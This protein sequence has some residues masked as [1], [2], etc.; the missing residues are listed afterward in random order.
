MLQTLFL[1]PHE[2]GGLP[3]FGFGWALIVWGIACVV[4]IVYLARTQGFGRDTLSYIPVLLVV[5]AAI[6][7]VAP[8]MEIKGESPGVGQF[9]GLPIRGYGVMM[10]VGVIASVGITVYRTRRM[11][12]DPEIIFSLAFYMFLA[13]I[14]GARLF[15]VI[16]YWREYAANPLAVFNVTQG[17]LVVYGSVLGGVPAGIY[18]LWRRKLPILAIGDLIAPGMLIGLAFGRVGCLMNG[19]CFGG[20]CETPWPPS[21]S[22]PKETA[23]ALQDSPPYAHQR[24][25]GQLHGVR[26]DAD[27]EGRPVVQTI[28]DDAGESVRITLTPGDRLRDVRLETADVLRAANLLPQLV[29]A[30]VRVTTGDERTVEL[31]I[32]ESRDPAEVNQ[33]GMR[34][35]YDDNDVLRITK[36]I[37]GGSAD[38]ARLRERE[39]IVSASLPP[40]ADIAKATELPEDTPGDVAQLLMLFAGP[41]VELETEDGRIAELRL[42][43]LPAQTRPVHP[44]QIYSAINA[45]LLCGFLWVLYPFR[46][47]DGEV[48]A[49]MLL[50]YPVARFLLESIRNDEPAQFGTGLTIAQLVSIGIFVCGAALMIY[51]QRRPLCSAL[52]PKTAPAV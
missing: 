42:L 46:R 24:A 28:Y 19:C 16:E 21:I 15:F 32:R 26:L 43:E 40:L 29:G 3:V 47:R 8:M 25:H 51:L 30:K 33:I 12:L 11:G 49:A 34:A 52:P 48:F 50:L 2:I 37:V 20:V 4:G 5:A 23:Y 9:E 13:G 35:R 22:F 38:L 44:T 7:Y 10:L 41:R 31:P 39:A 1:I 18:F 36:L 17:G 45:F 6:V 14:V 27:A